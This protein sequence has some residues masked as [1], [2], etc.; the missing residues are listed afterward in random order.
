MAH[1]HHH[2]AGAIGPRLFEQACKM[3]YAGIISKRRGSRYL[4][5]RSSSWLVTKKFD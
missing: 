1:L 5:G 2:E 3:G 4:S